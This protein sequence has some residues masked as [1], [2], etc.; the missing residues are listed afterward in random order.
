MDEELV[1]PFR[2]T[3]GFVAFVALACLPA[4]AALAIFFGAWMV[5]GEVKAANAGSDTAAAQE[6]EGWKKTLV[7]ICPAH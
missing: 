7:G 4:I 1:E 3:P 5:A 2:V 6:V